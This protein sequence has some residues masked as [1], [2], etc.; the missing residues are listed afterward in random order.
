LFEILPV[1]FYVSFLRRNK[2]E[3]LQVVFIYSLISVGFEFIA[4]PIKTHFHIDNYYLFA[5]FTII[6]YLLLATFL[7]LS[8]QDRRLKYVPVIGTVAFMATVVANFLHTSAG[9]FDSLTASVENVLI[10]I[11]SIIFLYGQIKDPSILFVYY[12]KKFWVVIACFI[13]FSATLFLFLYASNFSSQEHTNF[14]Y[15]NTIFDIIKNIFFCIAFS[16]KKK[17]APNP[18]ENYYSDI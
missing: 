3:G 11:Y 15:I 2:H 18:I 4:P 1:V 12:T 10:I 6:E 14:W 17:K 13:Y 5:S 8:I 7:Y 9:N 16:M